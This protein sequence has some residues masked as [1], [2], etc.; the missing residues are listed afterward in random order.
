MGRHLS[1]ETLGLIVEA[2]KAAD[3]AAQ[4]EAERV[5]ERWANAVIAECAPGGYAACYTPF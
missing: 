5:L 3:M 4:H 2:K 1:D